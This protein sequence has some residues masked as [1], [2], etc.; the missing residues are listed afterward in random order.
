MNGRF[1]VENGNENNTEEIY[2]GTAQEAM[3]EADAIWSRMSASDR[4]NHKVAA[5]RVE[6]NWYKGEEFEDLYEIWSSDIEGQVVD[7]S[8]DTAMVFVVNKDGTMDGET[9]GDEDVLL[10]PYSNVFAYARSKIGAR[11]V[12]VI[13]KRDGDEDGD[14]TVVEV[15]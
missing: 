6:T 3:T 10:P 1:K 15:F 9:F 2:F 14:E 13:F 4:R 8:F 7:E 11:E 12:D 5:Y